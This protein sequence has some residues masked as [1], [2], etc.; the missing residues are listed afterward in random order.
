MQPWT[1]TRA[2]RTTVRP[3]I[4]LS[5]HTHITQANITQDVILSLVRTRSIG[6]LRDIRRLTVALSRA[7][8]GLYILG[9]TSVFESCFELKPAFDI[10][11]ARPTK[12]TLVTEELYAAS[13]SRP[14]G[15]TVDA[16][17]EAVMEGVEH[18]GQYV[19]EMT[20]AKIEAL[21]NGDAGGDVPMAG[22][23]AGIAA[24]TAGDEDA[25]LATQ[26]IAD[27]M[28][29]PAPPVKVDGAEAEEPEVVMK[30]DEPD[31][32]VEPI[33][34]D[35]EESE[36]EPEDAKSVLKVDVE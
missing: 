12:L 21:K 30:V 3:P 22:T 28:H 10:L 1:S 15:G 9:R 13:H 36:D 24:A 18:L 25:V 23:A 11:L 14:V 19:Y 7:R 2:S 26:D 34:V 32:V 29:E 27:E 33:K 31:D 20:K 16:G 17:S 5:A 6:Y 35:G 4:P 8:L